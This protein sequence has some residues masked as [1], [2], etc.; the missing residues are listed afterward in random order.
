AANPLD[1]DAWVAGYRVSSLASTY[2]GEGSAAMKS[3]KTDLPPSRSEGSH[4]GFRLSAGPA[5]APLDLREPFLRGAVRCDPRSGW[6]R[7]KIG[8]ALVA[9]GEMARGIEQLRL[10]LQ[11]PTID[12]EEIAKEML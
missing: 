8:F 1:E 2:G 12:P 4:L 11:D 10:S 6:L 5:A 7:K 9:A 3:A